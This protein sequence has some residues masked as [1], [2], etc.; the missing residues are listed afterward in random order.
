MRVLLWHGY[1]LS[2]SGSNVYTANLARAWRAAGHHVLVMC[3]EANADRLDFVDG[4]A[5][6]SDDNSSIDLSGV[7]GSAHGVCLVAP[8]DIGRVLPVYVYDH[9][10]GFDAKRFVDL[11]DDELDRYTSMNVTAMRTAI[12]SFAPDAIVTGHE[13]MGPY[14][15]R[16]ACRAS[17]HHY[18]AKLHGSALEYAVKV[19]ERYV[20]FASSGLNSAAVVVG[21][22]RYMIEAAHRVIP[23]WL[24]RSAVVNPGCD[25]ELFKPDAHPHKA[26]RRIG[27]VG[28][29]IAS[30]GVHNLLAAL[31]LVDVSDFDAVIV[32]YGGFAEQLEQLWRAI[33][34]GDVETVRTIASRGED[35]PLEDVLRFVDEGRMDTAYAQR[36]NAIDV[37]FPGRLDHGPLTDALTTFDVLVAPSVV[38]EAFGMVAAEAAACGV[39]PVVPDHSGISE[40]GA[41][42]EDAIGRPGLLTFPAADPIEGI[43][44]A[45][46]RVLKM[47][48]DDLAECGERAIA[49]ARARWSWDHV[50]ER[51]LQLALDRPE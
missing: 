15:A 46:S 50:A 8:P 37:S 44:A 21:G 51:L 35:G 41:A 22:S 39:L 7:E 28:K 23:G 13:V 19:Q 26:G 18:L 10:E 6:F 38:P 3:Q 30:K 36:A 34:A 31:P 2:G 40:A 33:S 11:S 42:V 48:A 20:P 12:A 16:E 14:I 32:G 49:L 1:L 24:A 9:Y 45:V 25:V 4:M 43:A 17:S 29:L 47:P 5:T 27:Y